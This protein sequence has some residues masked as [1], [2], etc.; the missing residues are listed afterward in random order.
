MSR[1]RH[2]RNINIQDEL[3][4]DALSD[5]GEEEMTDEEHARLLH[6]LEEVRQVLGDENVSGLSDREIKDVIWEFFFDVQ[7]TIRWALDEQK[8]KQLARDR[9]ELDF[10]KDLPPVPPDGHDG[11]SNAEYYYPE[12]YTSQ[13][14]GQVER[15]R[16]PLIHQHQ[17]TAQVQ[18]LE[19]PRVG[20]PALSTI[21]EITERTEPTPRLPPGRKLSQRSHRPPSTFTASSYG[22]VIDSTRRASGADELLDPNSIPVSPS[23]SALNALSLLKTFPVLRP[24]PGSIRPPSSK[25]PSIPPS[26]RPDSNAPGEN[27]AYYNQASTETSSM[28]SLVR[29]AINTAMELEA[30][31]NA[32][33]PKATPSPNPPTQLPSAHTPTSPS[34]NETIRRVASPAQRSAPAQPSS[35]PI[36]SSHSTPAPTEPSHPYKEVDTFCRPSKLALLAQK[37]ANK[38]KVPKPVTEYFTPAANGPTAT[39]AITTSVQTLH[40]L[41]DPTRSKVIPALDVV[42]FGVT[43]PS[44]LIKGSKLA[45]KIRKARE[46][47]T[48]SPPEEDVIPP[49]APIFRPEPAP[50]VR[51]P[52]SDFASLL[53]DEVSSENVPSQHM[54]KKKS[55]LKAAGSPDV[56]EH[57]ARRHKHAGLPVP[58][59]SAPSSFTFDGPSPDDIVMNARRG[60]SLHK[61]SRPN[62]TS[63]KTASVAL[64]TPTSGSTSASSSRPSSALST[65]TKKKTGPIGKKSGSSTPSRG[66]DARQLDLSALNLVKDED[67]DSKGE[68]PP[69]MSYAREKLLEEAKRVIE[70]EGENAKKGVSLVVVGHVDAGKSTLMG[71]LLYELG[72]IE[73][74]TRI[75]NERGSAKAGKSSFAWAWGLDG[76]T[77]ERERGITMDIALQSLVTPHRQITILDAPGHKDFIPNMISGASQLVL[78]PHCQA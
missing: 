44:P 24:S 78:F 47:Q 16:V 43:P 29:R 30:I 68:E 34:S 12:Q 52:P 9:K 54:E 19:T 57:K 45:A 1:H 46:K 66:M 39:T 59:L 69:P 60:T 67:I 41:S 15:S 76:T 14:I 10:G 49:V 35:S 37:N 11:F 62:A 75:A 64:K 3:D 27:E 25:A 56:R 73:E 48:A 53:V 36:S 42:P 18:E 26:P 40:S 70:A 20:R 4:D 58:D 31:D 55:S 77:E 33:T 23:L 7:E 21:T 50:L 74:K 61:D 38:S 22:E 5:G 17:T 63:R 8:K 51:G 6:A 72:R 71:R 28:T 65:P 13:A 2:Y 32:A